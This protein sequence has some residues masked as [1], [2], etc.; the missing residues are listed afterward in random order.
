VLSTQK[1]RTVLSFEMTSFITTMSVSMPLTPPSQLLKLVSTISQKIL[2]RSL[3]D[4]CVSP[5]FPSIPEPCYASP[6]V[7][8]FRD[9]PSSPLENHSNARTRGPFKP[10]NSTKG[11]NSYQLRQFAE[12]TLGN[13]SLRKVV[14]L[15]EGEDINEWLAVNSMPLFNHD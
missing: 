4:S 8:A 10:R 9:V 6:L 7:D 15:P 5:D 2:G 14:K 1:G 3:H 13:G 11:T 12:A